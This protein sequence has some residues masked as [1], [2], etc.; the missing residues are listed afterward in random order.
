MTSPLIVI[1]GADKGGVGKTTLSRAVLDYVE[2]RGAVSRPFD[3]EPGEGALR[4][5]FPSTEMLNVDTVPGQM[6]LIDA[7]NR[8]A[9]TVV[10]CRAGLLT[11]IMRAFQR[12]NL[13]EDIRN[14]S[15]RLLVLHV[16]GPTVSSASEIDEVI[17][18]FTGARVVHVRNRINPD[19]AFAACS[20]V[21][22]D[23]PNLDEES[24]ETVDRLGVSF[25]KFAADPKQSRVLRGYVGAWL[26]D[27]YAALDASGLGALLRE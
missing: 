23:V 21:S 18:G 22:I 20:G 12:I 26:A 4:R 10:D 2:K 27:V 16:V 3:T 24:C 9:V 11:P 7:A 8:E 14:G 25:A 13:L 6:K 17:S 5:F 19:A 15:L 1:V